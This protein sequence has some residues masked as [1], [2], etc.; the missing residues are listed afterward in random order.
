[1]EELLDALK[2]GDQERINN[3]AAKLFRR[4][5][6]GLNK[7]QINEFERYAPCRIFTLENNEQ[8][9]FMGGIQYHDHTYMFG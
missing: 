4:R 8:S 2:E 7:A 5:A 3:L 1:M 9:S 6:G